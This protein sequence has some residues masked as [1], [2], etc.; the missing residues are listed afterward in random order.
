MY[1]YQLWPKV[2]LATA[3]EMDSHADPK[4]SAATGR[5]MMG[6]SRLHLTET[7]SLPPPLVDPSKEALG[8]FPKEL[9][10]C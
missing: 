10:G 3:Q 9:I 1:F 8:T 7:T 5:V 4:V 6:S 2:L